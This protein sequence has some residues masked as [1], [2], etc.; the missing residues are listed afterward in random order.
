MSLIAKDSGG[1][2]FFLIPEDQHA[3]RCV[4]LVDI[5]TQHGTYQ[6]EA[7]DR[8]Q[9]IIG[10]E[11][12]EL[13]HVFDDAKGKEPAFISSFYTLSLSEKANLRKMLKSWRG[14]E[15]TADE[16]A[17][18]DLENVLTVPCLI[19]VI[20]RKKEDGN[21]SARVDAVMKLPKSQECGEQINPSRLFTFDGSGV[22][23]FRKLPEWIQKLVMKS[24][25]WPSWIR[26]QEGS[27][28]LVHDALGEPSFASD[29]PHEEMPF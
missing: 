4:M 12:P 15:F 23:D 9:V 13:M 17:G 25:E 16:L 1:G 19:Q 21:V 11:I 2:N 26:D 5:G 7:Y 20:H 8:R 18:F 14:R 6:G 3:A 10:W 22:E 28:Q 24:K 27:S 29:E